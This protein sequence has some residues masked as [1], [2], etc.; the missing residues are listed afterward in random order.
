[1]SLFKAEIYIDLEYDNLCSGCRFFSGSS[2]TFCCELTGE[3]WDAETTDRPNICPLQKVNV[4][5][6]KY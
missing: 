1:M 3:E 6:G 4:L 2:G 5:Y